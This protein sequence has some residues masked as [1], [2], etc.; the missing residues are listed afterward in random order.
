MAK[1]KKVKDKQRAKLKAKKEIT[2]IARTKK[3]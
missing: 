1:V 2:S 3:K